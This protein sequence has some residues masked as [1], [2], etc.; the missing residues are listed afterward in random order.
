MRSLLALSRFIDGV[1][2]WVGKFVVWIILIVCVI[3]ATNAVTRKAFD[4]SS[5]AWLEVQWYLFGAIF[6]LAAGYTLLN[7]EHVRVDILSSRLSPRAQV[8]VEI[9][10]VLVFMLPICSLILWLSWPMVVDS[11]V[12]HEMSSNAGG[13]VRWPVKLLVPVGFALLIIAGVSHLI[14]CV[15]YLQGLCPDPIHKEGVKTSEELL[16]EE[17]VL[18]AEQAAAE[19]A[20]QEQQK[21]R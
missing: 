9:F 15:G 1:T 19:H 10:G 8:K 7:N 11:Y 16:A 2:R 13:L 12:T 18:A 4:L 3:S 20:A 6:L 14:K 5:N 21:G 17:I